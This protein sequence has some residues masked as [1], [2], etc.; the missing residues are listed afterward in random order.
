M[1]RHG[2]GEPAGGHPWSAAWRDLQSLRSA[3]SL[4]SA[5]WI[6]ALQEIHFGL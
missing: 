5:N 1:P 3:S 2:Q 6:A 4:K